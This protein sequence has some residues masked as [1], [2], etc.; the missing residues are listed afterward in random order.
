MVQEWLG[1]LQD[2]HHQPS[3]ERLLTLR[4]QRLAPQERRALVETHREPEPRLERR[5]LAAEVV[6]PRAIRLLETQ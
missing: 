1:V 5:V 2:E 4:Q 6:A 3:S